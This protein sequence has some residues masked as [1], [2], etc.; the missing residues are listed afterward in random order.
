[1]MIT[2]GTAVPTM[3]RRPIQWATRLAPAMAAMVVPQKMPSMVTTRNARFDD[4]SG[5][6]T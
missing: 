2:V 3:T 6:T 4:R 1:M 5:S